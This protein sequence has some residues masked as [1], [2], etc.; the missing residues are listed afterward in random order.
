MNDARGLHLDMLDAV[1]GRDFDRL[2]A[3]YHPDYVYMSG[4]GIE[5]KGADA[6]VAVAQTY[7]KAFPDMDMELRHQFV[8]GPG[9]S[10]LELTARGTHQEELD[11]IPATGRA[12]EIVV[13]NVIEVQDG[14]IVRE[15][16]YYDGVSLLRQLGI[17]ED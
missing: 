9:A 4:D 5:Q 2:R 1:R 10:V 14:L 17:L 15:R 8:A 13:C 12:V 6:G 7:L 11:G 16:E 3:L